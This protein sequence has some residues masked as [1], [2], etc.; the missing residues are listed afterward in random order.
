MQHCDPE[1]L[2]LV[3]LGEAPI[4]TDVAAHIAACAQ[5]RGELESLTSIVS[6]G[7]SIKLDDQP[8]EPPSQ[9]WESVQAEISRDA[10]EADAAERNGSEF[11]D[12]QEQRE[13]RKNRRW[14]PIAVAAASCLV[15]GGVVGGLVVGGA[16][17]G[18]SKEDVPV[19]V[20]SG[21]LEPVPGGPDPKTTGTARLERTNG[22]YV[23]EVDAKGLRNPDGF[24]EVWMMNPTTSGLVAIGTFN[25]NQSKA[26]FPVPSGL[27]LTSYTSVDISDEP[28]DGVPGHS[29][30]SVLRGNL[31]T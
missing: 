6:V 17:I 22:Q 20:A 13:R 28:F 26:T 21:T 2:A 27:P 14:V 10:S 8:I 12:L 16:S 24:Y 19:T 1:D 30:V 31:A 18:T 7:R 4:D 25:A 15:L 3:A 9:V 23:L 5:C 29:A 11:V